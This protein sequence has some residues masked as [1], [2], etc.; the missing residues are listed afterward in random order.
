MRCEIHT[1]VPAFAAEVLPWLEQ[2]PV[3][4]NVLYTLI[5]ARSDGSWP[6]EPDGLWARVV[7]DDGAP[8]A[9]AIRTP[10]R[11]LLVSQLSAPAAGALADA[12]AGAGLP[13]VSGPAG[14]ARAFVAAWRERT[15]A[16]A[17]RESAQR[18]Y[19]LDAVRAPNGVPGRFRTA[20]GDDEA[21]I[22]RWMHEFHREVHPGGSAAIEDDTRRNLA[23]G[24]YRVWEVDGAPVSMAGA[25]PPVARVAR[26]G[27]VYTPPEHRRRGYAGAMVAALSQLLLDRGAVACMLY[28]DLANPTSNGVYQRIG[29]R[30]VA[31]DESWRVS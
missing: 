14:S 9:V 21:L 13:G 2:D 29:Y 3:L 15:G 17:E 1:D 28:A 27:P 30:P 25:R 19:R 26:V 18:T 7:G 31:D 22:V 16:R 24:Q 11:A 12:L 8:A 20:G 4:N 10:P 6:V 23:A 5:Q